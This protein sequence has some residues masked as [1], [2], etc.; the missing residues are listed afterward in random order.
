M[1]FV[2]ITCNQNAEKKKKPCY[3]DIDHFIV[4]KNIYIYVDIPNKTSKT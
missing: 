3:M 4:Q 1:S 2:M